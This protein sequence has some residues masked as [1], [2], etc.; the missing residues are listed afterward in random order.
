[1]K[2]N[3]TL[4]PSSPSFGSR[5]G[6]HRGVTARSLI[7]LR[8]NNL[9]KI[10]EAT[11]SKRFDL[12]DISRIQ[13]ADIRTVGFFSLKWDMIIKINVKKQRGFDRSTDIFKLKD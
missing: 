2:K 8:K 7:A 3:L 13:R 9:K 6:L 10:D 12:I 5:D 11:V 1:M 4:I